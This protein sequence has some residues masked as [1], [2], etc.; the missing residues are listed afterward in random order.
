MSFC[1]NGGATNVSMVTGDYVSGRAEKKEFTK[2]RVEAES[3]A[4]TVALG[5][6][7]GD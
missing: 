3:N 5:V 7:K 2:S 4:S 1:L 6:V